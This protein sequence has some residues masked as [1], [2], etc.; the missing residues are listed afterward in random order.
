MTYFEWPE[1]LEMIARFYHFDTAQK[2][3]FSSVNVTKSE[4][5]LKKSLIE[6]FFF[7]VV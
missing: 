7:C 4:E 3:K 5:I 2:M 6:N 1:R